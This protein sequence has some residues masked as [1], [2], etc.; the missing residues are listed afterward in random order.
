[1]INLPEAAQVDHVLNVLTPT[2]IFPYA[3]ETV[4]SLVTR[5]GFMSINLPPVNFEMLYAQRMQAQAQQNQQQE[6]NK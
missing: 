6:E 2:I 5:A 1:M 3:S 4:N